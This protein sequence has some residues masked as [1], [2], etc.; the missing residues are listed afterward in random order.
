MKECSRGVFIDPEA[1]VESAVNNK[2]VIVCDISVMKFIKAAS[3][4]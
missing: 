1:F 4:N 2:E 3:I